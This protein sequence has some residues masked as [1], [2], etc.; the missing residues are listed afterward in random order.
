[1]GLIKPKPTEEERA[2]DNIE[3]QIEEVNRRIRENEL[4][5]E[6][7]DRAYKHSDKYISAQERLKE[8]KK[9]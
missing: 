1:M 7:K 6:K 9:A 4:E 8:R 5:A 3:K 2:I